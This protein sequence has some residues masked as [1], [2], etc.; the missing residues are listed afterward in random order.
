MKQHVDTLEK[1]I[2]LKWL[3]DIDTTGTEFETNHKVKLPMNEVG[4]Y[5]GGDFPRKPKR[6]ALLEDDISALQRRR[7][8]IFS[9]IGSSKAQEA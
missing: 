8:E 3:S 7:I 1:K 5:T 6:G 2:E 9:D 4:D